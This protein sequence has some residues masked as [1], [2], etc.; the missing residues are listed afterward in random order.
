MSVASA[1]P[2]ATAWEQAAK[3]SAS[4]P[5]HARDSCPLCGASLHPEQEWCLRC[6]AAART[7]LA[8]APNWRAP[9]AVLAVVIVLSLGVLAAAFVKLAGSGS[10]ATTTT[11]VTTPAAAD[12]AGERLPERHDAGRRAP[13]RRLT[14]DGHSGQMRRRS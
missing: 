6:G 14:R 10:V 13:G 4:P 3:A 8:A 2:P 1:H 11:T 7:R 12:A 9:V 5:P